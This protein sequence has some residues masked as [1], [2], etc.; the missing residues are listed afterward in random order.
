M[1]ERIA[2]E[3]IKQRNPHALVIATAHIDRPHVHL[4]FSISGVEYA[5]GN[6][7]RVSRDVLMR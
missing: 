6:S 5:T 1:L 7:L 3:Y 4:H 2:R